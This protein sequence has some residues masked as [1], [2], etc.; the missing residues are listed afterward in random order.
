MNTRPS[1]ETIGHLWVDEDGII[2]RHVTYAAEPTASFEM[3]NDK[4]TR[5]GGVIGS[6]LLRGLR[7][8][9]PEPPHKAAS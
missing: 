7:L 9:V 2:W 1:A 4:T 8:L 5:R 3:V 6:P